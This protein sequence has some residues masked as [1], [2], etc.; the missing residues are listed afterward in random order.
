VESLARGIEL[1]D[2]LCESPSPLGLSE[3]AKQSGLSGSMVQRISYTLHQLG[4]IDRDLNTKIYR[5]GPHM[6]TLALGVMENLEIKKVAFP[7]MEKL[8]R[9]INEMV[10]LGA[11]FGSDVVLIERV[12]KTQQILTIHINPGDLLPFNATA[13]GKVILAFLP[14]SEADKILK[15]TKFKKIAANTITSIRSFKNQTNPT[16]HSPNILA[17]DNGKGCCLFY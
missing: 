12:I 2:I 4:L 6:I 15:K 17:L 5:I 13:A 10:G 9:E 3:L 11:L 1:L 7:I 16:G 14:E 8:S